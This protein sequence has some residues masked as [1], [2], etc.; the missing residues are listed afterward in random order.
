MSNSLA[1]ALVKDELE[2]RNQPKATRQEVYHAIDTERDY[3]EAKAHANGTPSDEVRPHSFEEFVLYMEDYLDEAR[4]QVSRVWTPD[5]SAPPEA[6][7]TLL[8]VVALGVAAMEQHGAPRR[9]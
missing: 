6:L 4:H 2:R 3:Q 9:V 8:K 5:R 1:Q 7:H